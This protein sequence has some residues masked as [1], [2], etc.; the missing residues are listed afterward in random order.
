MTGEAPTR[1]WRWGRDG[2]AAGRPE[3]DGEV[4]WTRTA[5]LGMGRRGRV[6]AGR[7]RCARARSAAARLSA[8]STRT[9]RE[10]A[11]C[12]RRGPL[13]I[14]LLMGFGLSRCLAGL[15]CGYTG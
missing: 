6:A 15:E 12:R 2:D 4:A 11:V 13:S 8:V 5:R 10:C 14:Y 3:G 1:G 9:R 7:Q